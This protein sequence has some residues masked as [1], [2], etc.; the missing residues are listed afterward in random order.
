M[1]ASIS[2]GPWR[3]AHAWCAEVP[4][5]RGTRRATSC[6]PL[7]L[8]DVTPDLAIAREEVFGPVL[9]IIPYDSIDEAVT[10][11]NN[12]DYGLS[13]AVWGSDDTTVR[14]VARRL[15]SGQVIING[16]AWN[17]VAPFGGY[18]KSGLGRESGTWGLE[19]FLEVKALRF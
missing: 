10:I 8:L 13:A 9:T 7:S 15:R 18:K 1:C 17:F 3:T 19:E 12:T 4:G 6:V 14:D 11:A 5:P 2:T 16:G